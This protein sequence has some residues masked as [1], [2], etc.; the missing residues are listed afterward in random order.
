LSLA[1]Q[2]EGSGEAALVSINKMCTC[3]IV[4][5]NPPLVRRESSAPLRPPRA[6]PVLTRCLVGRFVA[7]V[8]ADNAE[9]AVVVKCITVRSPS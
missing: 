8:M 2:E 9:Q 4:G 3:A 6:R 5:T 1:L 7:A